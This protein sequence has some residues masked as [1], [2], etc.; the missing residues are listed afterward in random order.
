MFLIQFLQKRLPPAFT[1]HFLISLFAIICVKALSLISLPI[2]TNLLTLKEFGIWNIFFNTF[3]FI[4]S[5]MML[6]MNAP[7]LRYFPQHIGKSTARN[8]QD[9][10]FT[11]LTLFCVALSIV[12]YMIQKPLSAFLNIPSEY[13]ST[14]SWVGI[15]GV[16]F[17]LINVSLYFFRVQKDFWEN[18]IYMILLELVFV[19]GAIAA[20]M[21]GWGVAGLLGSLMLSHGILGIYILLRYGM[22]QKILLNRRL[23][24]PCLALGIPSAAHALVLWGNTFSDRYL[25]QKFIGSEQVALYGLPCNL[26]IT[27]VNFLM[28]PLNMVLGPHIV[29]TWEENRK[30]AEKKLRATMRIYAVLVAAVIICMNFL[31]RPVV[32]FLS[33]PSYLRDL[34][35]LPTFSIGIFCMGLY[36]VMAIY[37]LLHERLTLFVVLN[38]VGWV[39]NILMNVF[40]LPRIGIFASAIAAAVSH[41]IIFLLCLGGILFILKGERKIPKAAP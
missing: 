22:W 27:L 12:L 32:V 18:A 10:I 25:I 1:R 3:A 7:I 40:L 31:I 11:L 23:L 9:S 4:C 2:F 17:T 35:V 14:F 34:N 20:L 30:E 37:Y 36:N 39:V 41:L 29:K 16:F 13:A 26:V 24:G 15:T 33:N 6:G 5:L 28:M 19:L 21:K 38:C 8:F